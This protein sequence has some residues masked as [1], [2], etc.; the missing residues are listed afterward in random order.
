M[1]QASSICFLLSEEKQFPLKSHPSP[2]S[3]L[4]LTV[5]V[6]FCLCFCFFHLLMLHWPELRQVTIFVCQSA[7]EANI[8]LLQASKKRQVREDVPSEPSY[9]VSHNYQGSTILWTAKPL[10]SKS[11]ADVLLSISG[12]VLTFPSPLIPTFI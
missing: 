6:L 12:P 4:P 10:H 8:Q 3:H 11:G 9:K 1:V 7:R 5:L 2:T